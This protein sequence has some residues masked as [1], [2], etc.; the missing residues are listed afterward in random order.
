MVVCH[1]RESTPALKETL[2]SSI[3]YPPGALV[4][5]AL[6]EDDN[7]VE[8]YF[9]TA[10]S[11]PRMVTISV[12][13]DSRA[14]LEM[15]RPSISAGPVPAFKYPMTFDE[16]QVEKSSTPRRS[17]QRPSTAP[18]V[19]VSASDDSTPAPPAFGFKSHSSIRA[20]RTPSPS[21]MPSRPRVASPL[22][23]IS[24]PSTVQRGLG[25]NVPED[26]LQ[27]SS[28]PLTSSP[29]TIT[30]SNTIPR[31]SISASD[32]SSSDEATLP[33]LSFSQLSLMMEPS[34]SVP[35]TPDGAEKHFFDWPT[36][37][38]GSNHVKAFGSL[39]SKMSTIP[40]SSKFVF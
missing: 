4:P 9:P 34:R 21:G 2:G 10:T 29:T 22:S 14:C 38:A 28:T 19:V 32:C 36:V 5:V 17:R 26:S 18:A 35:S 31:G 13:L 23:T 33:S 30:R 7:S 1:G 11:T 27:A 12:W 37:D 6:S 15:P 16:P 24:M 39:R 20:A 25:I 8:H 3:R 40:G